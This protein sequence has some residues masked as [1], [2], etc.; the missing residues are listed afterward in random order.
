M[1]KKCAGCALANGRIAASSE[2]Q[3]GFPATAP[4][5]VVFLDGYSAGNHSSF[6]GHKVHL[7]ACDRMTTFAVAE[8]VRQANSKTF[9][10]ALMKIML[11]YGICHTVVLNKESKF[12][13]EFRAMCDLLKLNVH[14]LSGDNHKG[15]LVERVNKYLNKGL[16]ILTN[17]RD[18]ISTADESILLLIYG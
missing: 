18:S 8:P 13:K 17:K 3:Y 2:L 4:F 9:A 7:I 10:K 16:R 1:C 6:D 11:R 12:F 15:M 14:V 5:N